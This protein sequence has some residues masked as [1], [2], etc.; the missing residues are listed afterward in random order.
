MKKRGSACRRAVK[1]IGAVCLLLAG[2]SFHPRSTTNTALPAASHRPTSI[3]IYPLPQGE[4]PAPISLTADGLPLPVSCCYVSAYPY[5]RRWPGH[6]R[7]TDQREEAYFARLAA[8]GPIT[9]RYSPA[10]AFSVCTIRPQ[11]AKVTPTVKDD[12]ISFTLPH[13][14]G[15]TI[16]LDGPHNA[17]HLFL[18]PPMNYRVSPNARGVR[19]FGAGVHRIGI[20]HLKHGGVKLDLHIGASEVGHVFNP[21]LDSLRIA[22]TKLNCG[23]LKADHSFGLGYGWF[24]RKRSSRSNNSRGSSR[25]RRKLVNIARSLIAPGYVTAS[26]SERQDN[27]PN[28]GDDPVHGVPPYKQKHY[29]NLT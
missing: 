4:V 19:Y 5:N 2:C 11:S 29:V 28:I 6:Q 14:G 10:H 1:P 9:F 23:R 7:T 16:E 21:D 3:R 13:A 8:E 25:R 20:L 26:Q 12:T 17:L 24:R 22:D 15:Y 18:D 27:K